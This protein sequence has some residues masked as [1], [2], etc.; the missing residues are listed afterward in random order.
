MRV[1]LVLPLLLAGCIDSEVGFYDLE[2]VT[3]L[4]ATCAAGVDPARG[5]AWTDVMRDVPVDELR[6]GQEDSVT[7]AQFF[8]PDDSVFVSTIT[9]QGDLLY[10]GSTLTEN[11]TVDG[12]DLGSDFSALLEA[13]S[14]GCEFDLQ[15]DVEMTFREDDFAEADG[16]LSV[17]LLE[18][19]L[20]DNRCPVVSCLIEY[21]FIAAHTG[22]ANPG[23]W[24]ARE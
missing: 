2:S 9:H 3:P 6:V 22:S 5:A 11:A 14:V 7:Q 23:L 16:S 10:S 12:V 19:Q 13:D 8:R 1:L 15:V 24:E 18:T 4:V 17:E 20:S 21:G